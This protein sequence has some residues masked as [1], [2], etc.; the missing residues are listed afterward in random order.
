MGGTRRKGSVLNKLRNRSLPEGKI[1]TYFMRR[2]KTGIQ[3]RDR[4]RG[5]GWW[6][7]GQ[8]IKALRIKTNCRGQGK[9]ETQKNPLGVRG[10][11]ER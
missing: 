7:E 5:Y 3:S 2:Q 4:G 11:R 1:D 6:G 10:K 8:H 9:E